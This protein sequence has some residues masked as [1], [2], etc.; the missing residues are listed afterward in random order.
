MNNKNK[1]L[2]LRRKI[3][4]KN[5]LN[6]VQNQILLPIQNNDSVQETFTEIP[7]IIHTESLKNEM[8]SGNVNDMSVLIKQFTPEN[9]F[10]NDLHLSL[11][12]N[13]QSEFVLPHTTIQQ[14]KTPV[15]TPVFDRTKR[16]PTDDFVDMFTKLE[17]SGIKKSQVKSQPEIIV[18]ESGSDDEDIVKTP[19]NLNEILSELPSK[20]IQPVPLPPPL[21]RPK[22]SDVQQQQQLQQQHLNEESDSDSEFIDDDDCDVETIQVFK[23]LYEKKKLEEEEDEKDVLIKTNVKGEI[24]L[25]RGG[26]DPD[27]IQYEPEDLVDHSKL[28]QIHEQVK[29][30][31]HKQRLLRETKLEDLFDKITKSQ[32]PPY[33]T[34][35]KFTKRRKHDGDEDQDDQDDDIDI[36]TDGVCDLN[37]LAM[38]FDIV[39]PNNEPKPIVIPKTVPVLGNPPTFKFPDT[40]PLPSPSPSPS[41]ST[42]TVMN[43]SAIG[44][45]K[46]PPPPSPITQKVVSP[47][48]NISKQSPI[49]IDLV[50]PQPKS[51]PTPLSNN[52]NIGNLPTE[53]IDKTV[54]QPTVQPSTSTATSNTSSQNSNDNYKR[55]KK[56][57]GGGKIPI[58]KK[59]REIITGCC[60]INSNLILANSNGKDGL[61]IDLLII[62]MI[63]LSLF[64]ADILDLTPKSDEGK[65]FGECLNNNTLFTKLMENMKSKPAILCYKEITLDQFLLYKTHPK[66]SFSLIDIVSQ[67]LEILIGSKTNNDTLKFLISLPT[68]TLKSLNETVIGDLVKYQSNYPTITTILQKTLLVLTN[69]PRE[70]PVYNRYISKEIQVQIQHKHDPLS[71]SQTNS[72]TSSNETTTQTTSSTSNSKSSTTSSQP[73]TPQPQPQPTMFVDNVNRVENSNKVKM[74]NSE[75]I[76]VNEVN[77]V[78]EYINNIKTELSSIA[79]NQERINKLL[80]LVENQRNQI[81]NLEKENQKLTSNN[82]NLFQYLQ[83]YIRWHSDIKSKWQEMSYNI[84][85]SLLFNFKK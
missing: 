64:S 20:N 48:P 32:P 46:D 11:N 27:P 22:E 58:H 36:L 43:T 59:L 3:Q 6:P 52:I 55:W 50:S 84:S 82:Q 78:D 68:N 30:R 81:V 51:A 28:L 85:N 42:A 1:P 60:I 76:V 71:T 40:I 2:S 25:G 69:K 26:K 79:D 53:S 39:L 4:P 8:E 62:A 14:F 49:T 13:S 12:S 67:T 29:Q 24:S 21:N 5:Q 70:N 54:K 65:Q 75:V 56:L 7:P 63:R 61:N 37:Q 23:Q 83:K 10:Q 33:I 47:S 19:L 16:A 72:T 18:L 38:E 31:N 74:N 66:K 80:T 41:P 45:R 57:F 17:V 9:L 44:K 34:P 15:S 73:P 35:T 77:P